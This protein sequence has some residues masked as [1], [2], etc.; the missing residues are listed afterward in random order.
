M[1]DQVNKQLMP[2]EQKPLPT[3]VMDI[4]PPAGVD[5]P[6]SLPAD[7]AMSQSP[8]AKKND[9]H[10]EAADEPTQEFEKSP[11]S[12]TT[13][14]IVATVMIVIVLAVLATYAYIKTAK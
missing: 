1:D 4:K 7:P 11:S 9:L 5:R 8:E 6:H 2:E 13:G 10:L 14:A 12:G 3:P